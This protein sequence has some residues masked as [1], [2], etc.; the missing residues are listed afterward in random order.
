MPIGK[1]SLLENNTN[2]CVTV[3]N[4]PLQMSSQ[5]SLAQATTYSAYICSEPKQ[6]QIFGAQTGTSLSRAQDYMYTV[7]CLSSCS[8]DY[9]SSDVSDFFAFFSLVFSKA[10]DFVPC[11]AYSGGT[12]AYC[13]S[14]SFFV[15][16]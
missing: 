3:W 1:T 4:Q 13:L 5:L 11:S 10:L 8:A 14:S 9:P 12:Y 2:G 16:L 6:M 7:C 15:S